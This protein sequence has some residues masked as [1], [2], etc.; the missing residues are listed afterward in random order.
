MR[1]CQA[2]RVAV[3]PDPIFLHRPLLR[4]SKS[5][6]LDYCLQNQLQWAEDPSN[7]RLKYARNR[8]RRG[9]SQ[10]G[11]TEAAVTCPPAHSL[12]TAPSALRAA[13]L[14]SQ[15]RL[16]AARHQLE[17]A[18][19]KLLEKIEVWPRLSLCSLSLTSLKPLLH[20]P[21]QGAVCEEAL[22]RCLALVTGQPQHIASAQ[23]VT[24]LQWLQ[25]LSDVPTN[26]PATFKVGEA[27]VCVVADVIYFTR[28]P[29]DRSVAASWSGMNVPEF[30]GWWDHRIWLRCKDAHG[31]QGTLRL[32]TAAEV[33]AADVAHKPPQ[34]P[35]KVWRS[36]LSTIPVLQHGTSNEQLWLAT[37]PRAAVESLG[38]LISWQPAPDTVTVD[39]CWQPLGDRR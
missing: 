16:A 18:A 10:L 3:Q 28:A 24:L 17:S 5:D 37:A 21:A 26:A 9:L 39:S 34:L 12:H 31:L 20:S 30:G 13:L 11:L 29:M 32:P 1:S 36:A 15:V 6:L 7:A 4:F 23:P 35:R 14:D 38:L 2:Q 33:A 8:V 27:L 19:V 25:Q 22:R